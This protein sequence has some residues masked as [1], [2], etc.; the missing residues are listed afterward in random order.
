MQS[1]VAVVTGFD[2]YGSISAN[3]SAQV[4]TEMRLSDEH[5]ITLIREVLPTSYGRA[6]QRIVDLI[7]SQKPDILVMFGHS[8]RASALRLERC[9]RN[10]TTSRSRDNDDLKLEGPIDTAGPDRMDATANVDDV[11]SKIASLRP[12][13]YV[14]ENA[15]G[16]VCNYV[17]YTALRE[18]RQRRLTTKC[19]FAHLPTVSSAVERSEA[20]VAAE[21]LVSV[22]A[23]L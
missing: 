15:G 10:Q 4:V 6:S 23:H 11:L 22:V 1:I 13:P 3:P 9:A 14:S 7:R 20:Q 19:M 16:Y 17:Y 8:P 2:A 5:G 18:I 12:S 21:R